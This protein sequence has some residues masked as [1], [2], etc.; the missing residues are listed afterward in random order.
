MAN[1][2]RTAA[3]ENTPLLRCA[4]SG[5]AAEL[6]TA[7][8]NVS[9][10]A[11]NKRRNGYSLAQALELI[12]ARAGSNPLKAAHLCRQRPHRPHLEAP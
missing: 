2:P 4:H 8:Y 1:F 10:Y 9:R 5:Y 6:L 11:S 7:L 12:N 3:H